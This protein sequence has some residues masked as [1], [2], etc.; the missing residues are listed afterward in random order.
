MDLTDEELNNFNKMCVILDFQRKDIVIKEN[1]INTSLYFIING[2]VRNY[3]LTAKG[4]EKTFNFRME[5]MTFTGYSFYNQYFSKLNVECMEDCKMIQ[6][7]LE[8][9]L[10]IFDKLKRG[11]KLERFLA[12]AHIMELMNYIINNH[13]LSVLERY[14]DLDTSFPN[15]NQRVPQHILASY[16]GISQEHLSRIKKS[17]MSIEAYS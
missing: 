4:A 14:I 17:R 6:V 9:N 5:N 1:E 12:E 13:T 11:E 15:I 7:P 10:Y 2:L 3:I 8:A 16:L